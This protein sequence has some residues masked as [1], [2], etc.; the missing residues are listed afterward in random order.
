V[1]TK[2]ASPVPSLALDHL[3][4]AATTLAEGVQWCERKLG[5][6][7]G[8]GGE[9]PLMGTHNRLLSLATPT[10][11]L[12]YLEI[13]AINPASTGPQAGR[14]RWFALDEHALQQRLDQHGP[15]LIHWVARSTALDMHRSG[16]AALGL[17]PGE[18]VAASRPSPQGLLQ[19][20]LLLRAD[21]MLLH[22]GALPSLIQWQGPH[23]AQTMPDSGLGLCGLQLGAALPAGVCQL[24]HLPGVRCAKDPASPALTATLKT[25]L[26]TV[27]LNS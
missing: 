16:L 19:W 9:H 23:P 26:G 6:T 8:P 13:I 24:L 5:V 12:A 15:Q 7:P 25:P 27:Q 1:N 11:P 14:K 10:F 4:V 2:A 20:Q 18:P 21:G 17:E 22:G 3:V